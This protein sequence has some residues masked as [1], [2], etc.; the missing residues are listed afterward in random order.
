MAAH[1]DGDPP[2]GHCQKKEAKVLHSFTSP[3]LLVDLKVL[4]C[5]M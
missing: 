2:Y 1:K 5:V 4:V 3:K